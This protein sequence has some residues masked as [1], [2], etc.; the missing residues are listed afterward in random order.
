MM[1]EWWNVSSYSVGKEG[2]F[3]FWLGLR[4]EVNGDFCGAIEVIGI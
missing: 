4:R 3:L 2:Q 1:L